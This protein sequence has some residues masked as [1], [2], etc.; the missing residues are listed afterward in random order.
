MNKK[1]IIVI[2]I[3]IVGVAAYFLFFKKKKLK[4]NAKVMPGSE[5]PNAALSGEFE[6]SFEVSRGSEY[7]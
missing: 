7:L 4:T 1:V 6:Q 3:V 2:V 5:L